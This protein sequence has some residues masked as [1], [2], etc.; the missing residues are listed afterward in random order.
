[1]IKENMAKLCPFYSCVDN[2]NVNCF[3]QSFATGS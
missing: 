3:D 1:M 2:G